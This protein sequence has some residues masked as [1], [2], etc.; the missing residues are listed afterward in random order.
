MGQGKKFITYKVQEGETIQSI[1]KGLAITP[2]DLLKLN[3][4]VDQEIAAGDILVVPNKNYDPLLEVE[5][6][7]L[8]KISEKD[9]VVDDAIYHEVTPKETLYSLL[10]TYEVT[11][12]I[13][14]RDILALTHQ[15]ADRNLIT[16][17]QP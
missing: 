16:P 9:I 4:D 15:L 13:L 10:K 12:E 14:Q 7:D 5:S 17:S 6:I 8:S 1:A 11:P 2:Y 3:P